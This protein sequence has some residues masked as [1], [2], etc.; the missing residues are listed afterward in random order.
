LHSYD[1]TLSFMHQYLVYICYCCC[2]INQTIKKYQTLGH[3]CESLYVP[4][5]LFFLF[6]FAWQLNDHS[7]PPLMEYTLDGDTSSDDSD[8]HRGNSQ[9]E[10]TKCYSA[11]T[12][13]D[14][15]SS[16]D[17]ISAPSHQSLSSNKA[18]SGHIL[19][20]KGSSGNQC[21]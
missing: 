3:F 14:K 10:G 6:P 20:D 13:P 21:L 2:V 11:S 8:S 1:Q 12:S 9:T 16:L 7:T 4:L 5:F 15:N 17:C 18:Q 19:G